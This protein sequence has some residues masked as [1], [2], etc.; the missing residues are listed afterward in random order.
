M[1]VG[2]ALRLRSFA[3]LAA[4]C[5]ASAGAAAEQ[6]VSL[7][8]ERL[9]S[10]EK[11]LAAEVGDV[12]IALTGLL[13]TRMTVGSADDD[14]DG[15]DF[16]GNFELR[17]STQLPNRWRLGLTYFGQY[18]TGAST[19][20]DPDDAY[21]DNAAVSLGSAWGTALVGDVSGV[22]REQT[23]RLRGVGNGFLAFDNFLGERRERAGAYV[24][25]FGP[26]VASIVVDKD[27]DVDAGAMFQRPAGDKDWRFTIRAAEGTYRTADGSN[28]FDANGVGVI[29]EL[30]HGGTAFDMGVGHERLTSHALGAERWYV[31]AGVRTKT[32]VVSVSLEGHYGRI[33]GE[34]EV[35]AALGLQYDLARGLSA[36]LGLNHASARV[37]LG[38]IR[39]VDTRYTAAALSL[40]YSY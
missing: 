4:A 34:E 14:D 15:A 37:S 38:G 12:T 13:D 35:S 3:A 33:E 17:A 23:R 25:R 2:K 5:M 10:L 8:Y 27:G 29:G 20:S 30:I 22:V 21:E 24:G 39:L 11:P 40:R 28:R 36:N 6:D 18:A 16:A 32:G 26:W 1:N 7:N 19:R 9:S 31:S